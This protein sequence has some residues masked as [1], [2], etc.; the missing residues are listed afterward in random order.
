MPGEGAT[1]GTTSVQKTERRRCSWFDCYR[2]PTSRHRTA[3][4]GADT[5][6]LVR[7]PSHRRR[8]ATKV[9]SRPARR[10]QRRA[11]RRIPLLRSS[12]TTTRSNTPGS[13]QPSTRPRIRPS[14]LA[15]SRPTATRS[16]DG[17][18]VRGGPSVRPGSGRQGRPNRDDQRTTG[19][20]PAR[21]RHRLL[22]WLRD[23]PRR[24]RLGDLGL[25][26]DDAPR[27]MVASHGLSR[28][29]APRPHPSRRQ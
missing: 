21:V 7:C 22:R 8:R 26:T 28:S 4:T 27:R 11:H 3:A 17:G 25:R 19:S 29:P 5:Q 6:S 1:T 9:N 2:Y 16:P 12:S 10:P 18:S 24:V 20:V 14:V 15:D 23:D 13:P